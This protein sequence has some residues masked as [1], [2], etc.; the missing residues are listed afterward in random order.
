MLVGIQLLFLAFALL[1]LASACGT[2]WLL[3]PTV[4]V[5]SA[6]MTFD[7][8]MRSYLLGVNS[9]CFCKENSE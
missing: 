6:G 5:A 8:A 7:S 4:M 2:A 9:L 3:Y 1:A